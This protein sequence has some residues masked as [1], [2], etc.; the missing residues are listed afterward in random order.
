MR[1]P[2]FQN[3]KLL[4]LLLSSY[5]HTRPIT[6]LLEILGNGYMGR[7]PSQIF[8]ETVPPAPLSLRPCGHLATL[9]IYQSQYLLIH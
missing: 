4:L 2:L 6:L 7:P 3:K 5:F 8:W 1:K 9:V